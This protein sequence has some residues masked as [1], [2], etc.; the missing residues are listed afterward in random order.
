MQEVLLF[1]LIGVGLGAMYTIAAQGL[2]LIY[3][4][5]G[6]LNFAHGVVGM[7]GAYCFYELSV[8]HGSPSSRRCSSASCSQRRSAR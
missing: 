7:V 2:I 5:S 4:G 1:A 8:N 6:V 3:R